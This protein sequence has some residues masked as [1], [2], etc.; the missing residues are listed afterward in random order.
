MGDTDHTASHQSR[1]LTAGL[2]LALVGIIGAGLASLVSVTPG[3]AQPGL[4]AITLCLCTLLAL[5]LLAPQQETR[6]QRPL[7]WAALAALLTV[8]L[9]LLDPSTRLQWTALARLALTLFLLAGTLL[10]LSRK[11]PATIVVAIAAVLT[12]MPLWA[13]PLV[14]VAGNPAWLNRL[15]LWGSP[16]TAL[17][18]AIDLDYLR[19][20]WFYA[21]SALGSMRYAYPDWVSVIL[22]LAAAPAGAMI[23]E[24][25][26][27]APAGRHTLAFDAKGLA[28]G[29]YLARMEAGGETVTRRMVLLN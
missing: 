10:L 11:V 17:A 29:L 15:V 6:V 24:R 18:V 19:A 3:P 27:T 23:L 25:L 8:T 16:L 5:L 28:G 14:E 21:A 22:L 4:E 1:L 26:R 2:R 7:A 13:A 9:I 12:L 20:E